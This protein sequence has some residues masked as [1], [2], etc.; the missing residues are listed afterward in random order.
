M[1]REQVD[2][3]FGYPNSGN[4]IMTFVPNNGS[5][6]TTGDCGRRVLRGGS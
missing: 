3:L 6:W 2:L 1:G 5:A 4:Q